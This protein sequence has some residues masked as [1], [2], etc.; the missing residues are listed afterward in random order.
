MSRNFSN[1]AQRCHERFE[2]LGLAWSTHPDLPAVSRNIGK[3]T[4]EMP[5]RD[6]G[7]RECGKAR[8]LIQVLATIFEGLFFDHCAVGLT[9][10][11]LRTPWLSISYRGLLFL[12]QTFSAGLGG[13]KDVVVSSKFRF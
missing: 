6:K 9:P 8:R 2:S 5:G 13:A 3:E 1:A 12:K 10:S 7:T 11:T 4:S